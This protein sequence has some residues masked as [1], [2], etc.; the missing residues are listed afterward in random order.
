MLVLKLLI[1]M[2]FTT[3]GGSLFHKLITLRV[4]E[5]FQISYLRLL[6]GYR[7]TGN[8][9]GYRFHFQ[10]TDYRFTDLPTAEASC[11]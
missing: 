7:L 1:E 10:I 9:T 11:L 2:E 6:N 5:Y 3:Y 8:I 4:K